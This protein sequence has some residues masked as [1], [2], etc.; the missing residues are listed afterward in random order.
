MGLYDTLLN[1]IGIGTRETSMNSLLS[2]ASR[3]R[4]KPIRL[5][6]FLVNGLICHTCFPYFAESIFTTRSLLLPHYPHPLYTEI[7]PSLQPVHQTVLPR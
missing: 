4:R 1:G 3:M 7:E 6:I 2:A 5:L